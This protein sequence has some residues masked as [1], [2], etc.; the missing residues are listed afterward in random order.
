MI[1]RVTLSKPLLIS[2]PRVVLMQNSLGVIEIKFTVFYCFKK[3]RRVRVE[4][5]LGISDTSKTRLS[6][7]SILPQ[8]FPLG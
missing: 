2:E 4:L 5:V 3:S 6:F 1:C 7:S 8:I